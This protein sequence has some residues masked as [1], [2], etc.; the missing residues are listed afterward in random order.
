MDCE[1]F[2]ELFVDL[3]QTVREEKLRSQKEKKL[4]H[5]HT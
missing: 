3:S 2:S 1:R 5:I 4:A